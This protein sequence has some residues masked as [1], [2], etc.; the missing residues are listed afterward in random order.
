MINNFLKNIER[1]KV[2]KLEKQ[3]EENVTYAKKINKLEAI[4]DFNNSPSIQC[5]LLRYLLSFA[6]DLNRPQGLTQPEHQT[7][8][9]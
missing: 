7:M 2:I 9:Q 1:G 8:T 3:N 6:Q 4:A 5:H